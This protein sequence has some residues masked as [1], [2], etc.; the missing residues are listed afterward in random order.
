M[1]EQKAQKKL[2]DCFQTAGRLAR[3]LDR[4]GLSVNLIH[5]QV[6]GQGTLCG[7]RFW[8][9]WV[10][11]NGVALD[12]ANG[13]HIGIRAEKYRAAAR[14]VNVREYKV[15]QALVEV[16]RSQ[17]WGPWGEDTYE[18]ECERCGRELPTCECGPT[19]TSNRGLP[20]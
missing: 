3:D 12:M 10:E 9:A 19:K 4:A 13:R 16:V 7:V 20:T 2:G 8:H 1:R 5:A 11:T 17:H 6:R 14:A 15:V 18:P